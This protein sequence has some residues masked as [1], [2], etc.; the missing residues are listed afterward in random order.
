MPINLLKGNV[1]VKRKT[2]ETNIESTEPLDS[3][4]VCIEHC[5]CFAVSK[6][7]PTLRDY[8]DSRLR[9]HLY[10]E[11][12]RRKKTERRMMIRR[13][14]T[15]RWRGGTVGLISPTKW[16]LTSFTWG[17]RFQHL[18]YLQNF[19]RKTWQRNQAH[20]SVLLGQQ[21]RHRGFRR[22]RSSA[23]YQR[24]KIQD[25]NWLW[26]GHDHGVVPWK[27]K[28]FFKLSDVQMYSVE[29]CT[30]VHSWKLLGLRSAGEPHSE[31]SPHV[32]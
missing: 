15:R 21:A 14:K 9:H 6:R 19:E 2:I 16:N 3:S 27:G 24:E 13:L 8:A 30:D 10:S 17:K 31:S 11:P 22:D 23:S 5:F 12:R 28:H 29:R 20:N 32:D 25:S 26:Q 4:V 1:S 7:M 18:D